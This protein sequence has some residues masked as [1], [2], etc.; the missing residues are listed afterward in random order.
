M[1]SERKRGPALG[2]VFRN[3]K[4]KPDRPDALRVLPP[5]EGRT[6]G[7]TRKSSKGNWTEEEDEILRRAV[8]HYGGRNW[9]KIAEHFE[10][11]TD[12]QCL[13][14]WQK[15]LNPDLV[16]GSWT[17]EED[18]RIIEL[19]AKYGAKKWSLIAS[20]LQGRIGKQC[21]ERW[22]NHLNPNIKRTDWTPEE[23]EIL[24]RKHAEYGNQWAKLANFLDGR[25]DNAIKN[26]WN[27]T[28]KRR[29]ES[30]EF[31]YLFTQRPG[32]SVVPSTSGPA[33][34]S[35]QTISGSP[36]FQGARARTQVAASPA[37]TADT[38]GRSTDV[39]TPEPTIDTADT[40]SQDYNPGGRLKPS[41]SS[42]RKSRA[43]RAPMSSLPEPAP[44]SPPSVSKE[45]PRQMRTRKQAKLQQAVEALQSP[46]S[47]LGG[48]RSLPEAPPLFM[49]SGSKD[50]TGKRIS[51]S[52]EPAA[53]AQA[54]SRNPPASRSAAVH[55]VSAGLRSSGVP[56]SSGREGPDAAAAPHSAPKPGTPLGITAADVQ[57]TWAPRTQRQGAS[58]RRAATSTPAA[59]ERNNPQHMEVATL[60][61]YLRSNANGFPSPSIFKRSRP[62]PSKLGEDTTSHLLI[63]QPPPDVLFSPSKGEPLSIFQA[64]PAT[65]HGVA[66]SDTPCAAVA[67]KP[68]TYSTP[69]PLLYCTQ[70]DSDDIA[71]ATAKG[72]PHDIDAEPTISAAPDVISVSVKGP[73]HSYPSTPATSLTDLFRENVELP[74]MIGTPDI[75]T[76]QDLPEPKALDTSLDAGTNA[77]AGVPV[78]N[79]SR[80]TSGS[81]DDAPALPESLF[82]ANGFIHPRGRMD[83]HTL[84]DSVHHI[85][86]PLYKTA[87]QVIMSN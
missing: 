66:L 82:G 86:G 59:Q 28:L 18:Q 22:H 4:H 8:S 24:V 23:D 30:G 1:A 67:T 44:A 6:G 3:V 14:R 62:S 53:A 40:E 7:P 20:E 75:A 5:V 72:L 32:P 39:G 69:Y 50:G 26:H 52:P 42:A 16:K 83:L 41:R 29:V 37:A 57:P 74:S 9:K 78:L 84:L 10:G 54:S 68:L 43:V 55:P 34:F 76:L 81:E 64:Q 79:G 71:S 85:G 48:L 70:K 12:V 2:N 25:T 87:E 65:Q 56:S 11:K 60:S 46:T 36:A 45:Q 17:P 77:A 47:S 21:R 19:V 38:T 61:Q 49:A 15:V 31:N 80:S 27:S 51:E 33:H 63:H 73:L 58:S 35:Q 13:H